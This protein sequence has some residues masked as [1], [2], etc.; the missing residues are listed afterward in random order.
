LIATRGRARRAIC[1][2]TAR[3][4]FIARSSDRT[5]AL[6]MRSRIPRLERS[7]PQTIRSW[8]CRQAKYAAR[9]ASPKLASVNCAEAVRHLP[10]RRGGRDVR[11]TRP[12]LPAGRLLRRKVH[13]GSAVRDCAVAAARSRRRPVAQSP[14]EI[15]AGQEV[16]SRAQFCRLGRL[17]WTSPLDA[18]LSSLPHR[19]PLAGY[20]H[21]TPG[22]RRSGL[23]ERSKRPA[24]NGEG[25]EYGRP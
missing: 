9:H 4:I 17:E 12:R 23:Q 6:Q 1:D 25:D 8:P 21:P 19:R 14:C 16:E 22:R 24:T 2:K 18:G 11:S 3:R 20:L 10:E 7:L 15:R 13:D 5:S